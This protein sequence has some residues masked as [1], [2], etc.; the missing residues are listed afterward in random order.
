MGV[1]LTLM[2][3]LGTL[4]LLYILWVVGVAYG[5]VVIAESLERTRGLVRPAS[6]R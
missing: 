3:G 1:G 6:G 2:T 4:P 5:V